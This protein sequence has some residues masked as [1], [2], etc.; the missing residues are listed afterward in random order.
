MGENFSLA[1]VELARMGACWLVVAPPW[2][3]MSKR[4]GSVSLSL[5]LADWSGHSQSP[6]EPVSASAFPLGI[7][8]GSEV[9][10]P[11]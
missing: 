7:L 5:C 11:V 10:C 4:S 8:L 1:G 9:D 3:V 6:V 2:F